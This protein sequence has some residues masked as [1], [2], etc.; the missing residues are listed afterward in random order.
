MQAPTA[1]PTRIAL[2]A[3]ATGLVGR[4][5]LA[6]LLADKRWDAL[7]TLGRQALPLAHDKIQPHTV[8]FAALPALPA[9]DDVFIAL[10]TTIQVAGSQAAFKAVDLDAVVAV[11]TAARAAGA[12][13]LG[14]VSAMG[15]NPQS[16]IFYNRI[17]GEMET[18]VSALGYT[19]VVFARPSFLA[20]DRASLGQVVR[21][22]EGWALRI[23]QALGPLI[24]ANY[25]SIGA[26][27]VA[28]A[29]VAAV[30][31]AQ[32]GVQV[33]LSGAMQKA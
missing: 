29:L 23:S 27:Q 3:G 7:H 32:P 16:L 8:N 31:Q 19:R 12:T 22:G 18:A 10:G 21:P 20:G 17:K 4:E 33:L 28:R 2:L 13:R 25:R 11:A 6:L 5:L 14:V 30:A 9:V 26:P 1:P 15:A 24:P